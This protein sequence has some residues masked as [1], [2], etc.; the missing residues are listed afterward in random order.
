MVKP[1][2]N[3]VYTS[4][5]VFAHLSVYERPCLCVSIYIF[6]SIW[7]WFSRSLSLHIHET[8]TSHMAVGVCVCVTR[9]MSGEPGSGRQGGLG[10]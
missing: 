2:D 6:D 1:T 4:K 8:C 5:F 9:T 3:S 7:E 10:R